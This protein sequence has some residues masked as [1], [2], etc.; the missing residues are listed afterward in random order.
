MCVL[1]L[2][3]F[4]FSNLQSLRAV[5]KN[6]YL[7]FSDSKLVVLLAFIRVSVCDVEISKLCFCQLNPVLQDPVS[8]TE[9]MVYSEL[10]GAH[11]P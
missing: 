2:V 7:E 5:W 11:L 10:L 1:L 8:A 4:S 3:W 9:E 6:G